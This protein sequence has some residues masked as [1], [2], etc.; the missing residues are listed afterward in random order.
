MKNHQENIT[1]IVQLRLFSLMQLISP[2]FVIICNQRMINSNI[3]FNAFLIISNFC[4]KT[5]ILL[6]L[7]FEYFLE[8]NEKICIFETQINQLIRIYQQTLKCCGFE[9]HKSVIFGCS[10]YF[11]YFVME[12]HLHFW[13]LYFINIILSPEIMPRT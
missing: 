7:K 9:S 2:F 13:Y 4:K 12:I 6:D 10:K 11:F 1:I 8:I 3:Y 5:F